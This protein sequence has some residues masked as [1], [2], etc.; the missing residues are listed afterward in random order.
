MSAQLKNSGKEPE[1]H[2]QDAVV[3][4]AEGRMQTDELGQ[5]VTV[6]MDRERK[7]IYKKMEDMNHHLEHQLTAVTDAL[8]H[9]IDKLKKQEERSETRIKELEEKLHITVKDHVDNAVQNKVDQKIDEKIEKVEADMNRALGDHTASIVD[10]VQ[11]D[12]KDSLSAHK[13]ETDRK[14]EE[15]KRTAENAGYEAA[16]AKGTAN[17]A[18]AAAGDGGG[19]GGGGGGKLPFLVLALILAGVVT[20]VVIK[21]REFRKM[22]LL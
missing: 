16:Q 4:Y 18:A 15:V 11:Q 6:V 2:G 8:S 21:Y 9:A 14:V 12:V 1:T 5:A 3:E 13:D 17:N 20:V 19:G 22:H 10:S 7:D